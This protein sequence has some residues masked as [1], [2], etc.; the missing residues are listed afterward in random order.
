MLSM[1]NP[2]VQSGVP[3]DMMRFKLNAEVSSGAIRN[4]LR[5]ILESKNE[6]CKRSKRRHI[7]SSYINVKQ[8]HQVG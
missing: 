7:A 8:H 4:R 3:K 2:I 1:K 5:L 6:E